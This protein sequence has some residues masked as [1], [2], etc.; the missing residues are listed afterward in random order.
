MLFLTLN[1]SFLKKLGAT[2]SEGCAPKCPTF[3]VS[4][5]CHLAIPPHTYN[6]IEF[7]ISTLI[8]RTL[9]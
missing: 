1:T 3:I 4:R 5:L 6:Y 9:N 7:H 2:V 8:K